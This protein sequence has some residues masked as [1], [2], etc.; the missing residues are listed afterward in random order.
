MKKFGIWANRTRFW[1][2]PWFQSPG[3]A[4]RANSEHPT[5]P[6]DRFGLILFLFVL[7]TYAKRT[8]PII[9]KLSS[10][11]PL[12]LVLYRVLI[13]QYSK[14]PAQLS[15]TPQLDPIFPQPKP[16]KPP[17][18]MRTQYHQLLALLVAGVS[19]MPVEEKR[20]EAEC[21]DVAM[22]FFPTL[23]SVPTPDLSLA[24]YLASQTQLATATEDCKIPAVTGAPASAY[25]S[26]MSD[27]SSWMLAHTD[28]MNSLIEACSDVPEI[29]ESLSMLPGSVTVCTEITW[30]SP[31]PTGS[32]TGDDDGEDEQS[33]DDSDN[34]DSTND[35]SANDDTTNDDSGNDDSSNDDATNDNN[36]DSSDDSNESNDAGSDNSNDEGGNGGSAATRETG[37]VAALAAIA[38]A[39][40]ISAVM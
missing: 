20:D 8:R 34:G 17:A 9:R 40:L 38:M 16:S 21:A 18:T 11:A 27:L 13:Y 28:E 4:R 2:W 7:A 22:E 19:A 15:Q 31:A 12:E 1:T 6:R 24:M 32:S 25:S 3:H 35:D 36:D 33:N 39:G 26:W 5:T 23:T 37:T 10:C 29:A 30:E 14:A